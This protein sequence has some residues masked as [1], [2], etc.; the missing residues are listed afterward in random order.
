M[1]RN[2]L[3]S[4]LAVSFLF[5]I[6]ITV[7][8]IGTVV[9][10]E[11]RLE[12]KK[13]FTNSTNQIL[14]QNSQNIDFIT[15]TITNYSV[16][17]ITN[18]DFI[19]LLSKKY[20]KDVDKYDAEVKIKKILTETMLSNSL[21]ESIYL[22]NPEGITTGE[23][24]NRLLNN[25]SQDFK[26]IDYINKAIELKG[27]TIW[28]PPHTDKIF[29]PQT[30]CLSLVRCI[31]DFYSGKTLGV[32]IIN[33][34]PEV[35]QNTL[36]N[37]KLGSS[38]YMFIVNDTGDIMSHPKSEFIGDNISSESYMKEILASNNIDA[39]KNLEFKNKVGTNMYLTY[40][41][42]ENNGWKYIG[43]IPKSELTSSAQKILFIIILVS[44]FC[45][46]ITGL[47]SLKI[48]FSIVKP[49]KDMVCAMERIQDGDLSVSVENDSKDEIG[50]LSIGFN[51]MT[52]N[53]KNIVTA[54]IDSATLANKSSQ[55]LNDNTKDLSSSID[56]LSKVVNEI[57]I[58]ASNQSMN[59]DKSLTFSSKFGEKIQ[60]LAEYS[61]DV[62]MEFTQTFDKAKLGEESVRILN[63]HSSDNIEFISKISI[64]SEEL[65]QNTKDI[66]SI[67]NTITNISEQTNL[68]AL[69]AAIEAAR[70]GEAGKGFA[71]VAEEVRKLA[72][73]SKLAT[74]NINKIIVFVHKS[75][76]ESVSLS[77]SI[78]QSLNTQIS[79]VNRTHD[80]FNSIKN[81]LLT[82]GK[83]AN[84]LVTIVSEIETGKNAIIESLENISAISEET[85]AATEEVSA[86]AYEQADF[87]KKIAGMTDELKENSDKLKNFV[88]KFKI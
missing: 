39:S 48:S 69:N 24:K 38:G 10:I 82:V 43:V 28:I 87:T 1:K 47:I 21:I 11:T 40:L 35:F 36:N 4:K 66:K 57:A 41:T 17:L 72:E 12:V 52:K 84:S 32:L 53:L 83:K 75:T 65:T 31:S 34:N 51:N 79:E 44:V 20:S 68:L 73:E 76:Q 2:S 23:P 49:I 45:L 67:L 22:V 8:L 9:S 29:S 14:L 77:K 16:Q 64:S 85:A 80:V 50:L 7:L 81:S 27:E 3:S 74:E 78:A 15:S 18:T 37:A 42:S 6:I 19:N 71:V 26:N 88:N 63:K 30:K 55:T 60:T 54:V 86:S 70:A 46:V 58:G 25:T 56:D 33:I 59:A 61:K 62:L 5:I 13:D